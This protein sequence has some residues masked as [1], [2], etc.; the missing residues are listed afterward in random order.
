MKI[1]Y[2][3]LISLLLIPV[4]LGCPPAQEPQMSETTSET[5]VGK[6][7]YDITQETIEEEA[8]DF[9]L[10]DV[11]GNE[12]KLSDYQGKV[13]LLVFS[14]TWCSYCRAEVP[15]L[16]KLYAKYQSKGL[17]LLN[18]DIQ[19]SQKKVASFV[20]KNKIS[21]PVLLDE[22]GKVSLAYGIQGVPTTVLINKEGI[23]LCKVC[24][25]LDILLGTLLGK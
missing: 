17:V 12:V 13:V 9:T 15:H 14:T 11:A 24:R 6:K 5:K 21:Y 18:I 1:N 10:K 2:G 25:S 23:I 19:E 8:P 20:A 7:L 4:L 16:K 22:D 3:M